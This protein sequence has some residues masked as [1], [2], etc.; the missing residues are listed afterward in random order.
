MYLFYQVLDELSTIELGIIQR[1]SVR[2]T[3][4]AYIG[5]TIGFV[6]NG[7]IFP[8]VLATEEI[9][10]LRLLVSFSILFAHL[11]S[12]GLINVTSRMFTYFRS[13]KYKNHG[14]IFLLMVTGL[15][16][17]FITMV[18]YFVLRPALIGN[19]LEKSY[20]FTRYIDYLVPL[21]FFTLFFWLLDTYNKVLYD[22]VL[23]LFAK[24]VLQRIL[25]LGFVVLFVFNLVDFSQFVILYV[26][27]LSLPT[28]LLIL[29][30]IF[31]DQF[32]LKPDLKFL[33][34]NLV[35]DSLSVA[36][37]GWLAG[38]GTIVVGNLDSIMVNAM[39]DI[40]Q[41]GIYATTFIFGTLII[42]PSR[43]LLKIASAVI[44][45]HWKD[46]K[47][48]DINLIYHK[49]TLTQLLVGGWILVGIWGNIDNVF[50]ILPE[51]YE[52]GKYVILFIGLANLITMS[53]GV[54]G[55]VIGTSPYYR[56]QTY[57]ILVLVI[58]I[59]ILGL[60]LIP[61]YGIIGASLAIMISTL[62]FNL[63]RYFFL[64]LKY[65]MQPFTV[66]HLV[67]LAIL[68]LSYLPALFLPL[69]DNLILDILV[70]SAMISIVLLALV[71][72]TGVSE[73]IS[74]FIRGSLSRI[75]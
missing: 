59:V 49:S 56:V 12:L 57:A 67:A 37:W 28:L 33:D 18:V 24:E 9:G 35:R 66:K 22:A 25:I 1:Q 5:V 42:I 8:K 60:L 4:F 29:V 36:L 6:T 65:R 13:P 47:V 39:L 48:E 51:Q 41:T 68:F 44:A 3:I 31:R 30:L 73:D 62:I 11:G 46:M 38:S 70:R 72:I 71:M 19:N 21:I 54:A 69:L 14:F 17:F 53:F 34:N 32:S 58:S 61:A 2:G 63:V 7:L 27:A 40:S 26:V 50:R 43:S 16:G 20:L 52:A 45:D 74:R 15:A 10:L 55:N 75:F 23:G 64:L